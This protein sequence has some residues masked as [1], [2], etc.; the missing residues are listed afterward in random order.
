MYNLVEVSKAVVYDDNV[1][2]DCISTTTD[3]FKDCNELST[4]TKLTATSGLYK[5][6]SSTS[7]V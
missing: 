7:N 3:M 1:I 6:D 2:N 4:F 5:N